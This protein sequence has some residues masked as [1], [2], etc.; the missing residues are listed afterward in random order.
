[1]SL[2]LAQSFKFLADSSNDIAL[3]SKRQNENAMYYFPIMAYIP[4]ISINAV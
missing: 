3:F 4:P 2:F 1:M